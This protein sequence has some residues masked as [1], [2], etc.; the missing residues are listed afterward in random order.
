[1][2]DDDDKVIR[3]AD[4]PA[5]LAQCQLAVAKLKG[6]EARIKSL[7]NLCLVMLG[8]M[9]ASIRAERLALDRKEHNLTQ[10][11]NDIQRM[12]DRFDD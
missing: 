8:D 1:M 7:A 5:N 4:H 3:L 10:I 2:A 9:E 11:K 6:R 12:I